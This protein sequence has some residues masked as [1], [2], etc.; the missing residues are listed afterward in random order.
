MNQ[1]YFSGLTDAIQINVWAV[2]QGVNYGLH[3]RSRDRIAQRFPEAHPLRSIYLGHDCAEDFPARHEPHWERM[4]S[5]LTG[6]TAEQ[7]GEL[8]GICIYNPD[9]E[10]VVWRWRPLP[11]RS[12]A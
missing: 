6:L 5:M 4:S 9:T 8:G 3:F 10:E 1:K 7:I 11:A 12:T 2:R